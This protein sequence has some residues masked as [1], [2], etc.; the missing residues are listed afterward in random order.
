[1]AMPPDAAPP[2]DAP[3][4]DA[5]PDA[6]PARPPGV[7][8]QAVYQKRTPSMMGGLSQATEAAP[9]R[10][11]DVEVVDAADRSRVL[12]EGKTDLEGRFAFALADHAM[13]QPGAMVVVRVLARVRT[14][15]YELRVVDGETTSVLWAVSSEPV[16]LAAGAGVE[17]P[18]DVDATPGMGRAGAF[19]I[20]EMTRRCSEYV[21][22]TL[23]GQ[24]PPLVIHWRPGNNGEIGTSY[25]SAAG[26]RPNLN[27]L[28]G[29]TGMAGR[30]DT[31]EF[32]D[33]VVTHEYAHFFQ[34][35]RSHNVS[36]G[37][38]HGGEYLV[39]TLAWG[40]GEASYFGGAVRE[41]PEYIDTYGVGSSGGLLIAFSMERGS[42][43]A[44]AGIGSEEGVAE[45]LWDL[46][47]GTPG[48]LP[49]TDSDGVS[50]GREALLRI[51]GAWSPME[52]FPTLSLLLEDVVGSGALDAM[53]L[54]RLLTMPEDQKIRFPLAGEDQ[55]PKPLPL[56]GMVMDTADALSN[57]P[58]VGGGYNPRG[59][60]TSTRF[61]RLVVDAPR[62]VTIRMTVM[63]TGTT[64]DSTDLVLSLRDN[65][66]GE[67]ASSNG[68]NPEEIVQM[69]MPGRY[70]VKVSAY[71]QGSA[72]R[73]S[74]TLAAQ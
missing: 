8:G 13:L 48:T 3:P 38:Y 23:G 43:D 65:D 50:V 68:T 29:E 33:G 64:S 6:P 59:G 72:Q 47:D 71:R 5:P 26:G 4:P 39:P 57:P 1:M 14:P 63:G 67:L 42:N 30:S 62:M 10:L 24:N 32:D 74:Y 27:I 49:D 31:D 73:A 34:Y 18:F 25:F 69:L 51:V 40:E 56:G 15:A 16:T 70:I 11:V 58:T 21:I 9:I 19:N 44:V 28:G 20:V 22:G 41:D 7:F 37:G 17:V 60:Y 54:N 12:A 35:A 36:P 52:D 61:Y 2:P 53:A 55:C 66:D 46:A 45:V